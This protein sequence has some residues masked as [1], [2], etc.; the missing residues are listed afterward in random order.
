VAEFTLS[1][2]GVTEVWT[3]KAA[4]AKLE[5]PHDRL[6]D[7]AVMSAR[8]VVLGRTPKYHDLAAL[9]GGLR[10]HGGRYEEMVPF[11]V[12]EPLTAAAARQAAGDVRNFDI[13]D[14]TINGVQH[15]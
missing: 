6:G 1:L 3:R 14:V 10:S 7:L 2:P 9:K 11:V 15:G 5:L 13:F 4:A 8:N 12:S